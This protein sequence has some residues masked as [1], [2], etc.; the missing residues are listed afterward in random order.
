MY[1]AEAHDAGTVDAFYGVK[2]PEAFAI[3]GPERFGQS[4]PARYRRASHT[5][6]RR[7]SNGSMVRVGPYEKVVNG[8]LAESILT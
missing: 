7:L 5:V 6:I 4:R 2:K 1:C 8:S 3:T